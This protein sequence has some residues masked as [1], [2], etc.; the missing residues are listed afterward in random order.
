MEILAHEIGRHVLA[1]ATL[2]D[3]ARCLSRMRRALPGLDAQAPMIA[4]L[5]TDLLIND[6]LQRSAGLRMDEI[7]RRLGKREKGKPAPGAV[8][9]APWDIGDP[10]PLARFALHQRA[11]AG[12]EFATEG[13]AGAIAE[14]HQALAR[15]FG[16]AAHIEP[17]PFAFVGGTAKI[18][19]YSSALPGSDA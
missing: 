5:Y 18:P 12:L 19:Q 6:R 11:D 9:L 13:P 8:C 15:L 2:T 16:P 14:A 17:R 4:N 3:H 10:L 7:Y 1:P